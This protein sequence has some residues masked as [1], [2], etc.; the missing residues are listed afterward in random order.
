MDQRLDVPEVGTRAVER[1]ANAP[2]EVGARGER[3]GEPHGAVVL[4]DDDVGERAADVHANTR[5]TLLTPGGT[6]L[7]GASA[8]A[9]PSRFGAFKT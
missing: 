8:I 3:L 4:E 1:L 5:H 9:R 6:P 2:A 7:R